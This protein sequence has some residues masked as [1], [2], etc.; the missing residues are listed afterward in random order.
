MTTFYF[1]SWEYYPNTTPYDLQLP[2][3]QKHSK[4]V[5]RVLKKMGR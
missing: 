5:D 4:H 3:K 2:K 1:K